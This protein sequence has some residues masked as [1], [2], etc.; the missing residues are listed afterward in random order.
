[1][2]LAD[3]Q[4]YVTRTSGRMKLN[5][6]H[7]IL[8][9]TAIFHLLADVAF[10]GGAVLC[11]GANGHTE[12]EA[13]HVARDCGSF[14]DAEVQAND[15]LFANGKTS[16]CTDFLLHGDAEMASKDASWDPAPPAVLTLTSGLYPVLVRGCDLHI[17]LCTDLTPT[18]RA[19]RSIVL[20]I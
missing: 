5:R 8:L 14:R 3:R 13:G 9:L 18:M 20:I 10:A 16:D 17:G 4:V 1:M 7:S 12:I 11:V 15:P 6:T 19:H 2:L